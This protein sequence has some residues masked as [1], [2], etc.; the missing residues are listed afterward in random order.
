MNCNDCNNEAK[1]NGKD[2]NGN[3]RFRCVPCNKTFTEPKAKTLN[4]MYLPE[5]K[6]LMCLQLLVEGMSIRSI[7]RITGVH[8]DTVLRLLETV[9]KKCIWVQETLVKDVKVGFV[10]A[11]EI[12]SYVAMKDRTKAAKEITSKEVGSAYTFTA[13]DTDSKLIVAWQLGTRTESDAL[14][15]LTRLRNAVSQ[16]TVF[17]LSTDSFPGYNKAVPAILGNRPS[18]SLS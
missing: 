11:D 6:A 12:W 9:G 5:E 14:M 10:E 2:R 17:Q 8:R 16:D 18:T 1:R 15:F 13:I 7:E 3:Q 4:N